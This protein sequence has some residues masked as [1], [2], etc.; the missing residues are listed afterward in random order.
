MFRSIRQIRRLLHLGRLLAR[1]DALFALEMAGVS[2]VLLKCAAIGVR[3]DSTGRP[4]ERLARALNE[5]GPS[6]IK[7]G[8]A[9]STRYDLLGEDLSN[10]L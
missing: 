3:A 7:L 5:A 9:M 4:G 10:D 2:P 6:F 8:Q 1:H